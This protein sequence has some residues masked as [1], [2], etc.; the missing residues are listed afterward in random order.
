MRMLRIVLLLILA[1]PA[2]AAAPAQKAL[3]LPQYI[4]AL[5][6]LR[7]S[8][9]A[10]ADTNAVSSALESLPSE[11]QVEAAGHTFEVN[12]SG[13]SEALR[14]YEKERT[15]NKLAAVT[16]QLDLLLSDARGMQSAKASSSAERD[17]LADVLSRREFEK[18][19]GESWYDRL[20]QAAQRWLFN[21][22][23]R[24]VTSSA[25]PVVGRVVIWALVAL[26]IV[27]A[28]FWVVR[29]Y[30]QGNVYTQLTG[31]PDVVS[32]K[33]WRDWQAEAH[34]AAQA[35]RWRD[36]VHLS[37]WAAISFLEAQGLWR[38]DL[39]RTP[40]EYLKLLPE[41]DSHRDPLQELTRSFEKVWYGTDTAT[42]D[43]FA[44]T[45]ELLERLGCH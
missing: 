28:A 32:A 11:W 12:T 29:N 38:P 6:Q 36:A 14:D 45:S 40:R 23:Q 44:G 8:L 42:A 10:S 37:Y 25:F 22:L 15:P 34:A 30:R 33:P 39:A 19:R 1:G 20:K 16:A 18:V 31:S 5:Q 9:S 41:G 13:I 21:L 24:I 17:K 27:A 7:Q 2:L 35:G 26:A 4:E 43:T 3:S